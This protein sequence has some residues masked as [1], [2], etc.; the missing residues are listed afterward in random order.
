[1][2]ENYAK[3]RDA[4]GLKDAD[5]AK[6]T[7]ISPGTISDW[8]KGRYQ[9]KYDKLLRIAE[10]LGVSAEQLTGVPNSGHNVDYYINEQTAQYAQ[11]LFERPGLRELFD[12]TQDIS[13]QDLELIK[14]MVKRFKETNPDG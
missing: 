2:Y 9:L 3:I 10:F 13:D 8:K 7:G 6:A 5:V 12:V 1:M 11:V 4:K 14:N